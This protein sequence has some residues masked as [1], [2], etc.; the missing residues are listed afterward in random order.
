[1]RLASYK[2]DFW[3]LRSGETAHEANPDKFWIP[4]EEQRKNLNVGDAAKLI[5]DIEGEN[6]DGTIEVV[7]ERIFVIISEVI[8][9]YYIG[10]LDSQP[11]Y[12][13]PEDDFYLG[14]GVEIAFKAEH[15]I[16]V[17]RPPEDYIKWQLDQKPE[18]LWER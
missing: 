3:Q 9:E 2:L 8:N 12:V 14:F 13:E 16:D 6:E 11:A 7:G 18:K 4:E 1:M 17:N 10:I 5:F 15:V